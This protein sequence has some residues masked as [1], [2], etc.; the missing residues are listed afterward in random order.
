[1]P[2]YPRLPRSIYIQRTETEEQSGLWSILEIAPSKTIWIST[3]SFCTSGLNL[4]ILAWIGYREDKLKAQNWVKSDF[5][6]KFDLVGHGQS[7][8]KTIEALN[9]VFCTFAPKLVILAWTCFEL[10]HR[11]ASSWLTC[12]QM[13]G[14]PPRHKQWQYPMAK[15]GLR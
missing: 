11:Q 14:W 4:V 7:P 12:T 13:N 9:K 8:P 2:N 3:K 5:E 15:T 1:M 10:L 6:V